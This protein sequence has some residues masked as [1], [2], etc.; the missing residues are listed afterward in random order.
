MSFTSGFPTTRKM[1]RPVN[2]SAF[3][4]CNLCGKRFG[5]AK[6]FLRFLERNS[7]NGSC[8]G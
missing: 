4:I 5:L 1:A 7:G 6:L 3:E 2:T 8:E